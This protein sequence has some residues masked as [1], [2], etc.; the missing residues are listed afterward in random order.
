MPSSQELRREYVLNA[1]VASGKFTE[2][3][4][5]HWSQQYDRDP[6]GTE[7]TLAALASVTVGAAP[8]PRDL[9]PELARQG[10]AASGRPSRIAPAATA[11]RHPAPR[12]APP[13]AES[14][15]PSPEQVSAW[16]RALFPDAPAAD[17]PFA[18][19]MRAN[20]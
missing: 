10:R 9:F 8:Y 14:G 5:A 12:P 4:R 18:R 11:A 7:A 1:A 20:D 16:S 2:A 6:A 17:A 19:V 13:A 3:R 15:V